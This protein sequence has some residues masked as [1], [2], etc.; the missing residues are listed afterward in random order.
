MSRELGQ[1][2]RIR[3]LFQ[4]IMAL[5]TVLFQC[6]VQRAR[7]E[8]PDQELVSRN[9]GF[10]NCFVPVLCPDGWVRSPRSGTCFK[11]FLN[12]Q[13]WTEARDWCKDEG[14]DLVKIENRAINE[15]VN[16]KHYCCSICFT[17][18]LSSVL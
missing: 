15:I 11:V 10:V 13:T 18:V 16:G 14:G 4:G 9:Y 3:N 17:T 7:S 8:A 1:K 12:Q 2:P 6:Y 5:L